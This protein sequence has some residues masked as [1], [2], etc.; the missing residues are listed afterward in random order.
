MFKTKKFKIGVPWTPRGSAASYL[1]MSYKGIN[2]Q[3]NPCKT[4]KYRINPG[5]AGEGV[6]AF[7]QQ[8]VELLERATGFGTKYVGTTTSVPLD[9]KRYQKGTDMVIA[10]SHQNDY[11]RSGPGRRPRWP[12]QL[13][14]ARRRSNSKVVLDIKRPASP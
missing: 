5:Y 1:R 13:K 7:T 10:W 3:W 6:I 14:P 2:F 9:D 4:I 12:G 8:A 11:P